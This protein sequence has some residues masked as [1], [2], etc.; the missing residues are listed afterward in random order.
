MRWW[1]G[2]SW[3]DDTYERTEPMVDWNAPAAA[4]PVR[5]AARPVPGVVLTT[6]DGVPLAGWGSRVLARLLDLIIITVL[7]LAA[8]MPVVI[9]VFRRAW[10]EAERAAQ[11]GTTA[12][13][14]LSDPSMLE[15]LAVVSFVQLL[16]TL[17]Y[18]VGFLLWKAATPGKLATGLRV[19]PWVAGE[20]LG[21]TA[22]VRRW[23]AFFAAQSVPYIGPMYLVV[24]VIW[25]LRDARRQAL[26]DKFARTCVVRPGGSGLSS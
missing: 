16:V 5:T 11:T 17:V 2:A 1:D 6:E 26:H 4:A 21:P 12:S 14:L 24:D 15:K 13:S 25:P 7:T 18:E 20:R 9:D 8:S 10:D 22:A 3:T 19:R 23:L